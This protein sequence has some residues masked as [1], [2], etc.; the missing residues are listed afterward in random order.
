MVGKNHPG[1]KNSV[2]Q[3]HVVREN[4]NNQDTEIM[5]SAAGAQRDGW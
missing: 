2:S 4:M 3:G 5:L 1:R